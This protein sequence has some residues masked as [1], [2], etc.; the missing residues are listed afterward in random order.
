MAVNYVAVL[1][2]AVVTMVVGFAWY[3][4]MLFADSWMKAAGIDEKKIKE[5]QKG[6]IVTM[7]IAFIGAVVTNY[8]LAMFIGYAGA[9]TFIEG[10]FVGFWV[11]L[12]FFATTM[13]GV[14]L[15]EGRSWKLYFI[16]AG[17]YLVAL[18]LTGG[19]IAIM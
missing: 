1:I 10:S 6:M 13:M 7:L 4:K 12:G 17:H 3:S 19:V 11:W 5:K 18:L 15:W 2:A 14:V 8:V 9:S 16:N